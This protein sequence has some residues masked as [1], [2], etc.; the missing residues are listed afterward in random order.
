MTDQKENTGDRNTGGRNTGDWNTGG[1]NTGDWNTGNWN[2]GDW[3][4]G[5]WNAGDRNT[6]YW[7][8]GNWNA[9]DWNTGNWNTGNRNTDDQNTGDRNTGNRN[10]GDWNTGNWNTGDWNTGNWNAGDWNAGYF[11]TETPSKINVFDVITDRVDFDNCDKPDF[12]YF[13]LTVFVPESGMTDKEKEDN[14]NYG[15]IGGYLKVKDYKEAFKESYE[16][17]SEEDRKKIFNIPNF[18]ADKFFKISGIDVRID[19][20]L[21]AKKKALIEK[22]NELLKQAE[23]L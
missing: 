22:A 3:N 19:N 16:N 7:N 11:N 17:A 23:Q 13:E 14:E 15:N 21:Q 20:E 2:T 5:N 9:G 1:R 12:I 10:T 6:G 4:T 8:T 18:D